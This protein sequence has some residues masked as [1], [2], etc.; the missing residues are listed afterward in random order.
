LV[1]DRARMSANIDTTNGLCLAEAV[2]FA[3]AQH[4]HRV[5]AQ[6]LVTAMCVAAMEDDQNL[7]DLVRAQTDAPVDWDAVAR[8]ENWLGDSRVFIENALAQ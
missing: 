3:L 8:P 7:I 6:A 5:E 2:S 1:V 4:M